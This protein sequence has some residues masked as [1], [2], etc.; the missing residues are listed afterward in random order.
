MIQSDLKKA[1]ARTAPSERRQA[2]AVPTFDADR[3]AWNDNRNAPYWKERARKAAKRLETGDG[4][5]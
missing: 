2:V 3:P 5:G 1:H 4:N